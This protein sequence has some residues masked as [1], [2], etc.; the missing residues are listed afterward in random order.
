M[1]IAQLFLG[2]ASGDAF[3][4]SIAALL[5]FDGTNGSTTFTDVIGNTWTANGAAALDTSVKAFGTASGNFGN[6]SDFASASV[7]NLNFGTSDW[8]VEYQLYLNILPVTY[9]M[10]FVNAG[11][12]NYIGIKQVSAADYRIV[13][14]KDPTELQS[15]SLTILPVTF[16]AIAVVRQGNTIYFFQNGVAVGT[17]DCTG[18]SFDWSS[19]KIGA[20]A[21]Q[22]S[23]S[24]IDEFRATK[25]VA[26]YTS[27]YTPQGAPWPD[28]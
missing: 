13:C 19:A 1:T 24:H 15:S 14:A 12:T 27:S 8:T 5:H 3:F 2:A 20:G 17:A 10:Q 25:G 9:G 26:R 28:H 21:G 18:L 22:Q 16:Y 6:A 7:A 11:S 4:S 23:N